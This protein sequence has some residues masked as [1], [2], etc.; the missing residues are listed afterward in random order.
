MASHAAAER[1]LEAGWTNVAVMSD[2]LKG[3]KSA[4]QPVAQLPP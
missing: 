4:G 3:W 1:A 2:G